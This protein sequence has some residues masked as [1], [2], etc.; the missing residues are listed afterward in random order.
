MCDMGFVSGSSLSH[1]ERVFLKIIALLNS[2]L[3]SQAAG[4]LRLLQV[5]RVLFGVFFLLI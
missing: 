4:L 5:L 2:F 1:S 3:T